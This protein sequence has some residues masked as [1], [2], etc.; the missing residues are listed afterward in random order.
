MNLRMRYFQ[1][2]PHFW[3]A[4]T[5]TT[6]SNKRSAGEC[7]SPKPSVASAGRIPVKQNPEASG[8]ELMDEEEQYW[9]LFAEMF[10][11]F[12]INSPDGCLTHGYGAGDASA[13]CP[14]NYPYP[15]DVFNN[16]SRR[17]D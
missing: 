15:Q 17:G 7:D 14:D 5:S 12:S 1:P 4:A 11:E 8:L 2:E 6:I 13:N 9:E 16:E 3:Q 10:S